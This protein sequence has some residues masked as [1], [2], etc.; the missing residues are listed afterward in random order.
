MLIYLL[1]HNHLDYTILVLS[2]SPYLRNGANHNGL[3]LPVSINLIQSSTEMPPGQPS[4]AHT[5]PK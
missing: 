1:A 2:R 3:S 5:L 4:I